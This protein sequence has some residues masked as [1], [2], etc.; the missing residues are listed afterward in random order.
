MFKIGLIMRSRCQQCCRRDISL[1]QSGEQGFK[2]FNKS[3]Q[4]FRG[5]IGVK[6]FGDNI[7]RQSVFYRITQ[8]RRGLRLVIDNPHPPIGTP[9]NIC[10]IKVEIEIFLLSEIKHFGG[11]TLM[12]ENDFGRHDILFDQVLL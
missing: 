4:F 10:R 11:K 9:G 2:L 5:N 6:L 8:S 7:H 1:G 12:A 3:R